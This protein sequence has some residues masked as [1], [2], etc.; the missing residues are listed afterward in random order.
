MTGARIAFYAS[1]ATVIPVVWVIYLAGAP[2]ASEKALTQILSDARWLNR[3]AKR[4]REAPQGAEAAALKERN[5]KLR[6]WLPAVGATAANLFVFPVMV[7]TTL[8][9]VFVVGSPIVGEYAA[10]HALATNRDTSASRSWITA[11][12][13]VIA[14]VLLVPPTWRMIRPQWRRLGVASIMLY[15]IRLV[16]V[17]ALGLLLTLFMKA[18]TVIPGVRGRVEHDA[19][20][21]GG[22]G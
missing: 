14:V 7:L 4:E 3:T 21:T 1:V 20:D 17:V 5:L 12:L 6:F 9:V 19:D 22:P 10:L 2:E 13:V 11:S 16:P 15:G 8:V 18:L